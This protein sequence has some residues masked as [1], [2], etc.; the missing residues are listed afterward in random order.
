MNIKDDFPQLMTGIKYFDNA[1]TSL[2]PFSVIKDVTNYYYRLNSNPH[3]GIHRT[4]AEVSELISKTRQ[5]VA[6]YLGVQQ[7]EIIFTHGATE[8]LNI[9][10]H[11]L[12]SRL[13]PDDEVIV[14]RLEHHSNLLPWN[15]NWK[16][17][18]ILECSLDGILY[19]IDQLINEHTKILTIT[20]ESN[21]LGNISNF[22]ET[23]EKAKRAGLI[24]VV[25]AAQ[26]IVH[27]KIDMTNVDFLAFSGH[28]I[29]GP[30]GVGIL[31]GKR[32]LLENLPPLLFGGGM[33]SS[34]E[35]NKLD[36]AEL[37]HRLEAG[38]PNA[39]GIIALE[40]AFDY[41]T[42]ENFEHEQELG[43]ILHA[44]MREIPNVKVYSQVGPLMSFNVEGVHPH[45]VAAILDSEKFAIRA[46]Y[47]C[48]Q[49]LL[50]KL[51]IGPC[52]RASLAF[53]NSEEEI[54]DFVEVIKTVRQRMGL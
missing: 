6:D 1:A 52:C 22:Y 44:K 53:Y 42:E 10:A 49:P 43:K 9:I 14:T 48:A 31:Y 13:A 7:K 18:R 30:M 35:D 3:D 19:D 39:E 40:K 27:Q 33:I 25:D 4:S 45:D 51:E 24:V 36:L 38:T 37:P 34:V 26:A 23:I 21:V 16:N 12:I 17:C 5:R 15:Q 41:L 8:S 54:D 28:K 32:E 20:A 47:H 29:Y 50:D 46:G 2:K 11:G